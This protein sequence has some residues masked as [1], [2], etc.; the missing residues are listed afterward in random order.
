MPPTAD[1]QSSSRYVDNGKRAARRSPYKGQYNTSWA[2]L[3]GIDRYAD[4]HYRELR[5]A[6]AD[7][8]AMARSLIE[9]RRFLPENVFV[10]AEPAI[11]LRDD[12]RSW[13]TSN[14]G[15]LGGHQQNATK[16]RIEKILFETLASRVRADDCV[17]IYFAG[18]GLPREDGGDL[19]NARPYLVP[20][21][22]GFDRWRDHIDLHDLLNEGRYLAAKHVLYVLDAC[23]S[24]L[25]DQ[26]SVEQP[27]QF[28]Q[29]MLYR[30]ARQCLTAGTREQRADDG[31][32]GQQS[33][34]T[35]EL[36]RLL[37]G[38][39]ATPDDEALCVS[40]I[41]AVLKVAVANLPTTS[42]QVPALFTAAGDRGGE[43]VFSPRIAPLSLDQLATLGR[44]LVHQV[45]RPI[46]ERSP[47][48][49]AA[50]LWRRILRSP[51]APPRLLV[52]AQREHARTQLLLRN[53]RQACSELD[54][55]ELR[56]DADASLLRAAAR[57]RL[58]QPEQ[59][60][61]ELEKLVDLAPDHPYADWARCVLPI[62]R[63]ER[64]HRHALLIGVD[65]ITSIPGA[66]LQGCANDVTAMRELLRELGFTTVITLID[67]DAT[68]PAIHRAFQQL[69]RDTRPEDSFVCYVCGPG[70]LHR[71]RPVYPSHDL[72]LA[73]DQLLT[74]DAV[75]Q[76][77]RSIPAHDKLLIT[78][79][80]YLAPAEGAEPAGYRFLHACRRDERSWETTDERGMSRGA[81]TYALERAVRA[82]RDAP[83]EQ[84]ME[85]IQ[86]ELTDP[87]RPQRP[88]YI[89]SGAAKLLE[90]RAIGLEIIEL[91][92]QSH[93]PFSNARIDEF[94]HWLEYIEQ[95]AANT[96]DRVSMA[97][98]WFAIG[99][100]RLARQDGPG[101]ISALR[102]TT[103]PAALLPLIRAQ[104]LCDQ[105]RDAL[106]TWTRWRAAQVEPEPVDPQQVIELDSLLAACRTDTRRALLVATDD[107]DPAA[108]RR[109]LQ[110][111]RE[112][113]IERFGVPGSGIAELPN[114]GKDE[115]VSAFDAVTETAQDT[116]VFFLFIGPGFDSADIWLATV[117]ASGRARANLGLSELRSDATRCS[118]LTSALLI[119]RSEPPLQPLRDGG[120]SPQPV[121]RGQAELGVATLVVAP[122]MHR[123][124]ADAIG[125]LDVEALIELLA[126]RGHA[127]FT[128]DDWRRQLDGSHGARLRGKADAALLP[129]T[130]R[131][132]RMLE[133][134]RDIEQGA[135]SPTLALLGHLTRQPED[136][137]EAWLQ[138]A[139]I[140]AQRERHDDAIAAIDESLAYNRVDEIHRADRAR[141]AAAAGG[142]PE[143]HYHRG[144]ILFALE[145]YTEA[146][147][148]L[149]LTVNA[150]PEHARAHYY[151]ALAIQKLIETDLEKLRRQ[152][153][154][155][156]VTH[157]APFGLDSV[158]TE[159][160]GDASPGS[161]P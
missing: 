110:R 64:G 133:L 119:T 120:P 156:Y 108:A 155:Q 144:R 115:I 28:V 97:Q 148:E 42:K 89:G 41:A 15:R 147:A 139:I 82:S 72:D 38:N 154:H 130:A 81:F 86:G 117:G 9:H 57:L 75:D 31:W 30:K 56:H 93:G 19:G 126:R 152:S 23:C 101:A 123:D 51:D 46:D 109:V 135:L 27:K 35:G 132:V 65:D 7:A 95:T 8:V 6:A 122:H 146:E 83:V 62:A 52:E 43:F 34:F 24:G 142:A 158:T 48:E 137:A 102:R 134:V 26:R 58:D 53:T 13:L 10:I 87:Q 105:F 92:E 150:E 21:D 68:I 103:D 153:F 128:L 49:F 3:I 32:S 37:E 12:L 106:D 161:K 80:C 100:S 20:A 129:Y 141:P 45:G 73:S 96:G 159:R 11:P 112:A 50:K 63:R 118:H 33:P 114:A 124:I 151:R 157:G 136:A 5:F 116:P 1:Q 111:A 143:V 25:A 47:V 78:D 55:A 125:G 61:A 85:R 131:R 69:A 160:R 77:M 107:E 14:A 29:K 149:R 74:E 54:A 39:I 94:A 138:I 113:L 66:A 84:L 18:H 88:G 76:A 91:A 67:A 59:A 70:F 2:V 99:R 16:Q 127:R 60:A 44:L 71:E 140:Q 17:L 40:T 4:S 145:R 104:L 36:L 22:A 98:P 121:A 79:G 90:P